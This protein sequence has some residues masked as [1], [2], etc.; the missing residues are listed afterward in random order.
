MNRLPQ[1]S[2]VLPNWSDPLI[3]SK[4]AGDRVEPKVVVLDRDTRSLGVI[5]GR[6]VPPLPAAAP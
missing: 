5:A 4:V 3:G 2:K 1:S 6:I